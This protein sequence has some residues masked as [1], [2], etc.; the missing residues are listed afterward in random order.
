[1]SKSFFWYDFE[2]TG[3]DPRRDRPVQ[4]AGVRTNEQLE[5]IGEPLCIDCQL[6]D[7]VLP[8]PMA[9]LVTGIGPERVAAGLGEPE[10][11]HRLHEQMMVP[12]TCSVGYNSL[13]YDDE[14][15]RFTLYR[16]F[17]DP[18]ARE[19][20]GGNSRWD[21]LD[22]LRAAHALRPDGIVWPQQDGFTSLRLEA[23]TAAN[24]IDHGQA[25]DALADVRAT[26]AMARLLRQAQPRLFD[27]L[28]TLRS[29]HR[30]S[31]LID[32]Q[33]TRP[34]VHVSGRFGRERSGLGLVLPLGWHPTNRNAL[35]VYDLAADPALIMAQPAEEI[36]RLL[37]TRHE[38]L[39]VGEARP[40]LKLVHINKSPVL[41]DTKVLL[42]ADIERLQLD[43][44]QLLHRADQLAAWR[45]DAQGLL[46]HVYAHQDNPAGA[47]DDPELQ[48]YGSFI[49]DADRRLLPAIRE[50]DG[51]A[52]A[53]T[54]WP[55][56][57]QRLVDMLFR[58]RAR[59]FTASLN[60]QE[61][62]Q[63]Q[64]FCRDRLTGTAPGAPI[65][66]N[67][68]MQGINT[69]LPEADAQQQALLLAWQAEAKGRARRLG[70]ECD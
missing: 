29:K 68:F 5:E 35:I 1:M 21:L 54:Q 8:H 16:N 41:A 27:Y 53:A 4:V 59:N 61:R 70:I 57:D 40:G 65:T 12:G 64:Q 55:L 24:G 9:C 37:Y 36:R 33:S 10:F 7:D 28:L 49:G 62:A 6:P 69:L 2:S 14:M 18:Y 23:L 11:I 47:E 31:E 51:G 20:Q 39:A 32:L 19:W 60:E 48:L 63:W 46:A 26:I 13:R 66:L 30:V 58:Y 22:A 17:H 38:E 34:L 3:I 45:G 44:P 50:A 43:M 67:D 56:R 15:T 25:H 52:L 42:P